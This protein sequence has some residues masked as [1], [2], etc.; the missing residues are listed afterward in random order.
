LL[1]FLRSRYG[2]L[3]VSGFVLLLLSFVMNFRWVYCRFVSLFM[4][5]RSI[6]HSSRYTHGLYGSFWVFWFSGFRFFLFFLYSFVYRCL[7]R[8]KRRKTW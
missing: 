8:M 7:V 5:L 1:P 3:L 6:F 4:S 2:F